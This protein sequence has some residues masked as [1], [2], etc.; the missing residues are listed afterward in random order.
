MWLVTEHG[1][2]SAVEDRGDPT[3]VWVRARAREHASTLVE[4]LRGMNHTASLHTS[5]RADYPVRV[6]CTKAAFAAWTS[7]QVHSIDYDNFK[8]MLGERR[9]H[10]DRLLAACHEVWGVMRAHLQHRV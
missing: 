9:G 7:E 3:K 6:H 10:A 5:P 2:F 4:M 1:F 8:S